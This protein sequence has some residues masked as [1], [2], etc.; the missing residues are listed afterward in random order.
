ME[1]RSFDEFRIHPRHRRGYL[2][3]IFARQT[4]FWFVLLLVTMASSFAQQEQPLRIDQS[5]SYMRKAEELQ[6]LVAQ[7]RP[8]AQTQLAEMYERGLGVPQ[9]FYRAI[10][11]YRKAASHGHERAQ[12]RL[13]SLGVAILPVSKKESSDAEELIKNEAAALTQ[14]T[15]RVGGVVSTRSTFGWSPNRIILTQVN[16][17]TRVTRPRPFMTVRRQSNRG[18]LSSG[19][20]PRVGFKSTGAN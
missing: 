16:K 13:K 19:Q 14:I 17:G 15:I 10:D 2:K 7:D 1:D 8:D 4:L 12:I 11:L 9:N 20:K 6:L 18:L 3:L 5:V